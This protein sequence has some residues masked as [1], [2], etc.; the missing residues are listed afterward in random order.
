MGYCSW[1]DFI[2]IWY[3][4]RVSTTSSFKVVVS[5]F[6]VGELTE[7][8]YSTYT[9][10]LLCMPFVIR[11]MSGHSSA[12]TMQQR[13]VSRGFIKDFTIATPEEF[14][15]RFGGVKVINKVQFS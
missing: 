10:T 1:G 15:Q 14:V 12:R 11:S 2:L 9:L 8:S 6:V 7:Q 3:T 4:A 13:K 5:I